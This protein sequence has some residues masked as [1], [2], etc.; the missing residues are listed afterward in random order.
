MQK[1]DFVVSISN[2]GTTAFEDT[3][4][5]IGFP[6]IIKNLLDYQQEDED[7]GLVITTSTKH[8][9][10][11]TINKV[12]KIRHEI[13]HDDATPSI[14]KNDVDLYVEIFKEFV[15]QVDAELEKALADL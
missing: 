12:V 8:P 9:I 1:K 10:S 7:S 6:D 2:N 5:K 15:K 4:K 3:Y 11:N 14:T 13:I